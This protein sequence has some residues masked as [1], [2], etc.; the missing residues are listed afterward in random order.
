MSNQT[1]PNGSRILQPFQLWV[2]IALYVFLIPNAIVVY[3]Y[4]ESRYGLVFAGKIPFVII[5]LFGLGYI[6][7]LR[8]AHINWKNSLYLLPCA[9]I[10][11]V[12]LNLEENP[13]KH[14]H[15][16]EYVLLAWLLYAALSRDYRGKGLFILIFLCASLLGVV[17][18]LEQGIHPGRTYGWSDM[19][20]NTSSALIGVFTILGLTRRG[21]EPSGWGWT[22]DLKAYSGLLFVILSGLTGAVLMCVNLFAV[23]AAGGVFRGIY[24][25]WLLAWNVLFVISTPLFIHTH[26][27]TIAVEHPQSATAKMWVYPALAIVYYMHFLLVFVAITGL[28]FK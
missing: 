26:K 3:R 24:P 10:V 2:L 21:S 20:V 9:V 25:P 12:I 6:A 15:I 23:Q 4:I 16:P 7:Y 1:N 28:A 19:L 5:I 17:D 14:I 18:E 13:N 11:A 8:Q 22:G 27:K